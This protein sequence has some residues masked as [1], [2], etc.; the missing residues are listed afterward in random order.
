MRRLRFVLATAVLL[1]GLL[2]RVCALDPALPPSGNFDL[3]HW[4]L[5]LPVNKA[6]G[7]DGA[8]ASIAPAGQPNGLRGASRPP[9]FFTARDGAMVLFCPAQGARTATTKFPR[10]ELREMIDPANE[11]VNW[12][13]D[14]RHV[15]EATCRV[16][17]LSTA[18]ATYIGQIHGVTATGG[19]AYPFVKLKFER[20]AGGY[21]IRALCKRDASHDDDD[22]MIF[23]GV[24]AELNKDITYA[25]IANE[26]TLKVVVDGVTGI[27]PQKTANADGSYASSPSWAEQSLLFYFKAGNYNQ[28]SSRDASACSVQFY[29]LNANHT[30]LR[31]RW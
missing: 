8:A 11:A 31:T 14:G 26:R 10:C 5:H 12:T 2:P 28:D 3:T 24:N 6:G 30:G 22:T 1:A 15:L 7:A 9:L 18:G 25:I 29:V 20:V 16:T 4:K 27:I 17:Q 13:L 21:H 23:P 19:S